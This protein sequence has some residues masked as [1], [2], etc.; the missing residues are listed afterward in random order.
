MAIIS[1]GK[2]IEGAQSRVASG[3]TSQTANPDTT[4]AALAALETEV[5]ELKA[6]LRAAGILS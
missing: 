4:G 6:T 2:I 5:N 1:G 3:G